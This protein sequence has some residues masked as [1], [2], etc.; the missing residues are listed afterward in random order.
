MV[1]INELLELLR[2]YKIQQTLG[3]RREEYLK[4]IN[5]KEGE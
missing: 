4:G 3:I 5:Y 2:F 1:N